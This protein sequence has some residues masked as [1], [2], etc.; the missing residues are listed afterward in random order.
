[1]VNAL[2]TVLERKR[3][4]LRSLVNYATQPGTNEYE[5][6]VSDLSLVQEVVQ[7]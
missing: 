5:Q 1:M 4:E 3:A 6:A 2:L 7:Q